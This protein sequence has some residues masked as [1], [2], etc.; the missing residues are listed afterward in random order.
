MIPALRIGRM[1]LFTALRE[2]GRGGT[3]GRA[4]QRVRGQRAKRVGL[5]SARPLLLG[6]VRARV[7]ALLEGCGRVVL[8]PSGTEPVI[9]VT[10]ED[11]IACV[12]FA[13]K[14]GAQS[15]RGHAKR[16]P[17]DMDTRL[18]HVPRRQ[19]TELEQLVK[20]LHFVKTTSETAAAQESEAA[21]NAI[22]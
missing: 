16:Q 19:R 5:G 2:G 6:N 3:A 20:N 4:R 12:Q 15:V 14:H 21:S 10:V 11:G 18:H 17:H 8:R 7:K 9:R 13:G 22:E 1:P